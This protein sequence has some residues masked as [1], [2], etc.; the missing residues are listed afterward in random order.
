MRTRPTSERLRQALFN[1]IGDRIREAWLLDLFAGTGAVGLEALSRGAARVTFVERDRQ[2]VAS[3][4][5]N[6]GALG[7]EGRAE[8]RVE[9]ALAALQ[10][11]AE[12]GQG[13]DYVFLDPPYAED[14]ALPCIETLARGT[15]LRQ[16][17]VL[18]VQAFHKTPL[19]EQ[20]GLL[21]RMGSRRYGENCLTFYAKEVTCR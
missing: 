11:L 18:V 8:V 15:I 16:N 10:R 20:V 1:L 13:F 19:P 14:L 12:A 3:L 6:L 7:L 5:R 9:D 21:R 2:A 4:R 17:G